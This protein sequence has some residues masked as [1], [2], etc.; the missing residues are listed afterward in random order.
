MALLLIVSVP[1]SIE[2]IAEMIENRA[3]TIENG[4]ETIESGTETIE[5]GAE[6]YS[7]T[8]V[9]LPRSWSLE[10]PETIFEA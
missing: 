5:T 2:N 8:L 10:H 9:T 3:E 1:L 6:N 7:E 4:A